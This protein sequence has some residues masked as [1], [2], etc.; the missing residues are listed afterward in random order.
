MALSP[1][2]KPT[3]ETPLP[4]VLKNMRSPGTNSLS[5]TYCPKRYCSRALRGRSF[6]TSSYTRIVKPEQ[7]IP[8][9]LALPYRYGTESQEYAAESIFSCIGVI[10]VVRS[11]GTGCGGRTGSFASD[12]GELRALVLRDVLVSG[13]EPDVKRTE[14][15]QETIHNHIMLE[16][17]TTNVERLKFLTC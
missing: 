7:S 5:V 9:R 3:C 1:T 2:Y 6:P 4:V 12:D 13:G 17:N 15:W 8:E 14:L 16:H 10:G 11:P